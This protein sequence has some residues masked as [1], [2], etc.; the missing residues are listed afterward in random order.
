MIPSFKENG[1]KKTRTQ[2]RRRDRV[3]LSVHRGW[4]ERHTRPTRAHTRH[5][6][7]KTSRVME[8]RHGTDLQ[9]ST[10]CMEDSFLRLNSCCIRNL[11]LFFRWGLFWNLF[12]DCATGKLTKKNTY[13]YSYTKITRNSFNNST[14]TLS[15]QSGISSS[16]PPWKK[17][18]KIS[19]GYHLT[20]TKTIKIWPRCTHL[21]PTNGEEEDNLIKRTQSEK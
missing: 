12:S 3:R 7:D 17:S 5:S 19:T 15:Y 6:A 4:T 14:V 9:G 16:P 18:C 8:S 2:P 10:L 21:L 1:W 20:F 13:Q 11:A